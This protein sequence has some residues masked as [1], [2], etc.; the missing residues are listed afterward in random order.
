MRTSARLGRAVPGLVVA[1]LLAAG[2]ERA[3]PNVVSLTELAPPEHPDQPASWAPY[4]RAM[5]ALGD[6][7]VV[8]ESRRDDHWRIWM[9]R[10]DGSP[11]HQLS[12]DETGRDHVAAHVSP[13]GRHLVYL[14]LPAPHKNFDPLPADVRAPL[15]LVRL[16]G[17]RVAEDRILVP[18]A[19][20]YY[21]NRVALWLNPRELVYVAGDRTTRQLDVASGREEVLIPDPGEGF[22]ML[23]NPGRTHATNGR[24]NFS[25]YRA[26]ERLVTPRFGL[27][28]CQPYFTADGRYGFWMAP[29][30][31]VRKLDLE[32][33]ASTI[34]IERGSKWLPPERAYL[35]YP[36]ISPDQ[37]LLAFGAAKGHQGH[38]EG[39]YDVFVASLDPDRLEVVGTPV[40][41][42][43]SPAQDRFPSAWLAGNEL[44]RQRGEAPFRVTLQPDPDVPLDSW[45]FDFGDG[46]PP[47]GEPSHVFERPGRYRVKATRGDEA[48]G[49]E[50]L[51]EPPAPPRLL[52]TEVRPGGRELVAVFDEP[53]VASTA[54]VSLASGAAVA[55]VELREGGRELG[56]RLAQPLA[57]RDELVLEGVVD[58]AAQPN[59]LPATRAPVELPAWPGPGE[60]LAFVFATDGAPNRANDLETGQERSFSVLAH[61]RARYDAFGALRP[62]G[63]W[64]QVEG[65]A[66]HISRALQR[67]GEFT[68]EATLLPS[69]LSAGETRRLLVLGDREGREDL[70]L[71]VRGTQATLR[72]RWAS[73]QEKGVSDLEFARLDTQRPSHLLVSYRQGRLVAYQDG[74]PV[75]DSDAGRGDFRRWQADGA[76]LALGADYG[77]G[78]AFAGTLEGIALYARAFDAA[79]AAAHANAYL[80]T[81][82]LREPVPHPRVEARLRASSAV[83]TPQLVAPYR[84]ALVVN[85]YDVAPA[86]RDLVGADR[87]RVAHWA[88]LDGQAQPVSDSPAPAP[89]ELEPFERH[90]RLEATYVSDTLDPDPDVPFFLDVGR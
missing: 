19:R 40:R 30:G 42:S 22:G 56:V 86:Q 67:S 20:P 84:E 51:A 18:D 5:A 36:M 24:P 34:V 4:Y 17:D 79:E 82:S 10:L 7:F 46:S 29:G 89:L 39:D 66:D 90:T 59:A 78:H 15:H 6:G 43:F 63:G 64:F 8:W 33:G 69:E 13:D 61:G 12:P 81:V 57:A 27:R 71:S 52:R 70:A 31:H 47:S 44:G 16:D 45:R 74:H 25:V 83:P 14:S 77:G 11:E 88:V 68:L 76:R 53:V 87:I 72:L 50:V 60:G 21:Q 85:E 3:G 9:R 37:R 48:L 2:C 80:H 49:G 55:G 75:L 32:S 28:G 35:Y 58:R 38:F 62:A 54:K 23:V 1:L 26:D 73:E 65:A 41:Y